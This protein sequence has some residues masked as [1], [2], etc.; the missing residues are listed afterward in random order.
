MKI[1]NGLIV[2]AVLLVPSCFGQT[3]ANQPAQAT[4]KTDPGYTIIV[5]PPSEPFQLKSSMNIGIQ[6]TVGEKEIYW[7]SELGDTGYRAFKFSLMKDGHEIETSLFH[8]RISNTVRPSDPQ[9]DPGG[10]DSI[11]FVFEPGKSITF[12]VDLTKLYE[13]TEPGTYTLDV[14][15][16]EEDKDNKT[17]V[18][19]KPVTF[20]VIP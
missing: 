14:R 15:R 10:G 5:V 9:L 12:T 6:V 1:C 18:R 20:S 11:V 4:P 16:L 8:R 7:R 17:M 3:P 2:V 19:A 13:I